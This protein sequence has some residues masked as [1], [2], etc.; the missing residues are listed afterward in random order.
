MGI[1]EY[2]QIKGTSI[3][4][5]IKS[6]RTSKHIRIFFKGTC[7]HITK[8]LHYSKKKIAFLL[9]QQEEKIYEEYQK[10]LA[11]EKQESPTCKHWQTGESIS[12]QGEKYAIE[13]KVSID[14]KI[15]LSLEMENQ[16]LIVE[17]PDSIETE[18]K[19]KYHVDKA[20]KNLWKKHTTAILQRKLPYWSELTGILYSS[21]QVRDAIS[22][23]GSCIY[24]T[25]RLHFTSRLVMLPEEIMDAIMVHELCHIIHPNHSKQFYDLVEKYI[26]DYKEKDKWLK[27]HGNDIKF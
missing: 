20:I 21:F 1:Q 15:H 7:L 14:S 4:I 5:Q 12:Y 16:K 24:Q 26:P 3:P 22:K 6:Y 8:P 11:L 17:I 10:V 19:I 25:K 18:E 9:K 2:I 23:Y 27:Q 13:R